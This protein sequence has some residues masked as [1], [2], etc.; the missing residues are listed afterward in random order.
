VK[1]LPLVALVGRPNVGKSTL[2]NRL[3]GRRQAIVE[4]EP[5]TTR[6]RNYGECEWNGRTFLVVDTGGLDF[7]AAS[8]LPR[9]IR[10]QAEMAIEEAEVIVFMVDVRSGLTTADLEVADQLRRSARPVIVAANKAESETRR[11]DSAEFYD[12]GLGDP[13]AISSLHGINTGDLLDAVAALLP[14]STEIEET[15][16]RVPRITLVGRPNVG[17]SSLLNALLRQDRAVVSALPGT[18]RDATDSEC[19][20]EGQRL[21]LV[22]TAGIRKRGHVDR[23]AEQYGVLRAMKAIARSDVAVLVVD[24]T[25]PATAQDAHIAGYAWDAGK[26]LVIVVNK[27]DLVVPKD[28][29]TL[30]RMTKRL[31]QDLQ[32]VHDAPIV[33]TSALTRQRVR[34]ILDLA[35]L[36]DRE[37]RRRISTAQLNAAIQAAL[38]RHQPA[39]K[40]GHQLKLRYCTQVGS[41]PPTF[42]L[43]VN[44]PTLVHFS[45]KRFLENQ[46]R[47]E[48]GFHGTAVRLVFRDSP[49]ASSAA[50]R[51]ASQGRMPVAQVGE[52][53]AAPATSAPRRSRIQPASGGG[54]K[55]VVQGS[56]V[57]GASPRP[58]T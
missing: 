50:E 19:E 9:A 42:V 49:S 46:L 53:N 30:D 1:A 39:S 51:I 36:V 29:H 21:I 24:A 27:W 43:F 34:K 52:L 33:F 45:Y 54:V 12:L 28:E 7:Q 5:G 8:D 56:R 2:F 44:D 15:D 58:R 31:R 16:S 35:L 57:R 23:G 26:G 55:R 25:E 41:E 4:D 6:D 38:H 17:K 14:P 47:A 11:L 22:D 13:I 10:R 20:V 18:T 37:R 48:F 3:V 40:G 32:F